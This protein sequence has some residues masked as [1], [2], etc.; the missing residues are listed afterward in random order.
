MNGYKVLETRDGID[1]LQLGRSYDG[2]IDLLLTDIVMP[3]LGGRALAEELTRVRPEIK[4]V[5][6]SG[7]TC[8]RIGR[9]A[10]HQP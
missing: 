10:V 8:G 7:G 5:Y 1:A 6:M 4:V 9:H 2:A 3:G